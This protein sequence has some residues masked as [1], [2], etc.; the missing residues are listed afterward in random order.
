[1]GFVADDLSISR[2]HREGRRR[3]RGSPPYST[4]KGGGFH[5]VLIVGLTIDVY[6]QDVQKGGDWCMS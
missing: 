1:M 4:K 5:A 3:E 6:L 2:A